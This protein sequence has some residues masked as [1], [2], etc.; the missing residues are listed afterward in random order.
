MFNWIVTH[1][2]HNRLFVLAVAALGV[3][4]LAQAKIGGQT[5][6]ILGASQQM[7]HLAALS[8]AAALLATTRE[9]RPM[10]CASSAA[11]GR[12][13]GIRYA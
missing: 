7:A 4:L 13:L 10:R 2:L 11:G 3:A 12:C 5:G 1:S 8:A 6:D 9:T